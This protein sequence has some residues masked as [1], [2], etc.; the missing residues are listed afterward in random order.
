M[1]LKRSFLRTSMRR[2]AISD[3][4]LFVARAESSLASIS[5]SCLDA[6]AP[7][8][9]ATKATTM[10]TPRKTTT[11]IKNIAANLRSALL[12]LVHFGDPLKEA[13]R[14]ED[15][16]SPKLLKETGTDAARLED[17]KHLA[18]RADA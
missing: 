15:A 1:L 17:T 18:I 2:S 16:C 14:Q 8:A 11:T 13:W 4:V 12:D 10:K 9:P 3:F 5:L 7:L 6:P